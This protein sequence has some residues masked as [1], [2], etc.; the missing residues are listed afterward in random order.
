[1][2]PVLADAEHFILMDA[3][4]KLYTD[5]AMLRKLQRSKAVSAYQITSVIF[6]S[7]THGV[8]SV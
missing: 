7:H 2:T 1:M 6:I 8:P 4:R 3:R 5:V